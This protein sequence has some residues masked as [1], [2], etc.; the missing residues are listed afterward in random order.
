MENRYDDTIVTEG[1]YW[2]FTDYDHPDNRSPSLDDSGPGGSTWLE[3]YALHS[4]PQK[5]YDPLRYVDTHA[6]GIIG[7]E[8][9]HMIDVFGRIKKRE[10]QTKPNRADLL[11]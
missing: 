4:P 8:L 6:E 7:I 11:E 3:Y 2:E 1:Q 10:K 9:L 5:E